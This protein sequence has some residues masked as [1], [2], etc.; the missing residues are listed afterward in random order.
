MGGLKS[1]PPPSFPTLSQATLQYPSTHTRVNMHTRANTHACANTHTCAHLK[2]L[3]HLTVLF[4]A[5]ILSNFLAIRTS[6]SAG[7]MP[8]A[9]GSP[10]FG[11]RWSKTEVAAG[12]AGCCR[13]GGSGRGGRAAGCEEAA[14]LE[15]SREG[16][17]KR[18][19][20]GK[21]RE[22]KQKGGGAVPASYKLLPGRRISTG[23]G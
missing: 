12:R 17:G 23:K 10:G 20:K 3:S 16:G 2:G 4:L 22:R 1:K 9:R 18:E 8:A 13:H 6:S 21:G 14:G 7:P 11:G 5:T 15:K 19:K